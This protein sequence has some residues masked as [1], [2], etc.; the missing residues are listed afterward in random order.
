MK[1][2]LYKYDLSIFDFSV[3][4]TTCCK[5]NVTNESCSFLRGA[6]TWGLKTV[7]R[8]LCSVNLP[9]FKFEIGFFLFD[10]EWL[11]DLCTA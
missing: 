7:P 3:L 9:T 4:G 2:W 1:D 8:V 5:M 6:H 10:F 11:E